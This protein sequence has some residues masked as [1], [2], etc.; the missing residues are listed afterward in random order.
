M[1]EHRFLDFIDF[2]I[3]Q[4]IEAANLY[5]LYAAKVSSRSARELLSRMA[6][7]EREHQR[8]L[9]EFRRTGEN[10]FPEDRKVAD[11]HIADFMAAPM[12]TK[13]SAIADVYAF[14]MR[15]EQKA[16]ELYTRLAGLELDPAVRELFE[17]LAAE[18]KKHKHDL[19]SEYEQSAMTEN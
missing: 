1:S 9:E 16:F 6:A 8:K 17:R 19:E 11:L 10:R 3:H 18:E 2:A 7:V 15:A 4:E 12:L 14:A 5:E 13:E